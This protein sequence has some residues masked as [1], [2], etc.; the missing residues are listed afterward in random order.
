MTARDVMPLVVLPSNIFSCF[1]EPYC[2][3]KERPIRKTPTSISPMDSP[4]IK[5]D[6]KSLKA[7]PENVCETASSAIPIVMRIMPNKVCF[8][9]S[10]RCMR[11]SMADRK[12][13][14]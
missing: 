14:V 2:L 11:S 5:P 1:S 10:R 8:C 13:V 12:S 9:F 7:V 4:S 3:L 6:I